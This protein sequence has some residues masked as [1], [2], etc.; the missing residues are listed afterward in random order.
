[1]LF[2]EKN[3]YYPEAGSGES[4]NITFPASIDVQAFPCARR[5]SIELTIGQTQQ[6]WPF[7]PEARLNTERN[8]RRHTGINGYRDSYI[9][10]INIEKPTATA[11]ASGQE[12]KLGECDFTLAG[13]NFK[14][15]LFEDSLPTGFTR[16]GVTSGIDLLGQLILHGLD[17]DETIANSANKLYA[18]I[19][20]EEQMLYTG[21]L[22]NATTKKLSASSW[23]LGRQIFQNT[24]SETALDL[25]RAVA[26]GENASDLIKDPANFYFSALSFSKEKITPSSAVEDVNGVSISPVVLSGKNLIVVS[27][28][29]LQKSNNQ[30]VINQRALLP[31]IRHGSTVDSVEVGSLNA[32]NGLTQTASKIPVPSLQV[33]P[34]ELE[35]GTVVD[36]ELYEKQYETQYRLKFI[37]VETQQ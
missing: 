13:Y 8:N 32:L 2:I 21:D 12:Q 4:V 27:M 18:N 24:G 10:T 36:E 1:M 35:Q 33:I 31:D 6:M 22:T 11:P 37:T 30:C 23:L 5:R 28:N 16:T 20:L 25:L 26:P 9:N 19:V 34:F 7:D 3:T 17:L 29:I 15:N 14:L